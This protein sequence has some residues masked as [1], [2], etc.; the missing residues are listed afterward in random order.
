VISDSL[1]TRLDGL[2]GFRNI[3][4]HDYMALNRDLVLDNLL[5]APQDFTDFMTEI[6][7]WLEEQGLSPLESSR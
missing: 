1:G 5:K 6:R 4:V 7:D 2:S 3:L